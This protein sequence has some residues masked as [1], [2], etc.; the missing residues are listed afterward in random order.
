[1]H[2]FRCTKGGVVPRRK[3]AGRRIDGVA[4]SS[5]VGGGGSAMIGDKFEVSVGSD[6]GGVERILVE[7]LIGCLLYGTQDG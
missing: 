6:G 2:L 7:A 3:A 1:M 5:A 4:L